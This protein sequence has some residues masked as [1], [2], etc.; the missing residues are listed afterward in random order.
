MDKLADEV[1]ISRLLGMGVLQKRDEFAGEVSEN[2]TTRFVY[3]WRLKNYDGGEA[4]VVKW[5]RRSRFVARESKRHDTYSPAT[6]SHT[7][8][9]IP[10]VYLQMLAQMQ[11]SGTTDELHQCVLA[12]MDIKDAFLQVPQE[13][14]VEVTLHDVQYVVLK[15]LPGQRMGAKAWYWHF[16]KYATDA[17]GFTWS[18]IQPCIAKCAANVFMLHVDDLLFTGKR[19][20]WHDVFLPAMQHKFSVSFS[21]LG[22]AALR[23]PF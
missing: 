20:Y 3:D 9:L 21:V 17:L 15:N 7:N 8:N 11:S 12:C 13:N 2:L 10:I 4:P 6:G 22:D 5:M 1:G 23:S 18:P 14:V 19:Q 16:R